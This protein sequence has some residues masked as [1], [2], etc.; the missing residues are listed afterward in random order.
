MYS[1]DFAG[2]T[3]F[4]RLAYGSGIDKPEPRPAGTQAVALV[5]LDR[6]RSLRAFAD[7]SDGRLLK[8]EARQVF[9]RDH[10]PEELARCLLR[11]DASALA[12]AGSKLGVQAD[13]A[14]MLEAAGGLRAG[15]RR[16]GRTLSRCLK[17]LDRGRAREGD[18]PR[19]E[20]PA[21]VDAWSVR[22]AVRAG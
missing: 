1:G 3:S 7:F 22:I 13:P 21:N 6:S 19:S 2:C 10:E 20:A 16:Q 4:R 14:L 12:G 5:R 17:R 15:P 8:P 11:F 18:R 9:C